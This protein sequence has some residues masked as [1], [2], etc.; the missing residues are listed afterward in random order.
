M[1]MDESSDSEKFFERVRES[2][3]FP[4]ILLPLFIILYGINFRT[5]L[6]GDSQAHL[7]L[8]A[9]LAWSGDFEL[10][11]YRARLTGNNA[12]KLPYFV[13]EE[14]SG[15]RSIFNFFP[16]VILVPAFAVGKLIDGKEFHDSLYLWGL[17]GKIEAS[18]F[19][20]L[21]GFLI[22]QIL[23]R[24][25]SRT[26]AY[27]IIFA[28]WFATPLWPTSVDYLQH[29]PLM[30]FK[31]LSL[32]LIFGSHD[33]DLPGRWRF[34][35]GGLTLSLSVLCR[36]QT[37]PSAILI[38]CFIICRYDLYKNKIFIFILGGLLPI[39]FTLWY[40]K[41]VFGSP[42]QTGPLIWLNFK[43]PF[44]S[45]VISL[46]VNPSKGL[47][48]HSPWILIGI[49]G[50][51]VSIIGKRLPGSN[52]ALIILCIISALPNFF[53]YSKLNGWYGGRCWG[54]RYLMDL[55]PEAAL[56][57]AFG[58]QIL[59]GVRFWRLL[60]YAAI[61]ISFFIQGV[62]A[63]AF[64]YEWHKVHV[65]GGAPDEIW[66]WQVPNSQIFYYIRRGLVYMGRMPIKLKASPYEKRGFYKPENWDDR[67]IAWLQKESSFYFVSR[68]HDPHIEV[69]AP[70]E[71]AVSSP[72]ILDIWING[73]K[74]KSVELKPI[75]WNRI[76]LEDIPFMHSAFIKLE[77]NMDYMEPGKLG[78]H[79]A[80]A[81]DLGNI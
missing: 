62:G 37:L 43:N 47:F 56:L 3:Y 1:T 14:D 12:H 18:I 68:S 52:R 11:E 73:K 63:L 48:M 21:A 39:P 22:W 19:A 64:D 57:T 15:L 23:Y 66:L 81:I 5:L 67:K 36:Y 41:A 33:D 44:F 78:R 4:L 17:A 49:I 27:I 72:L 59:W 38:A 60:T 16:A 29:H 6:V 35:A 7:Y 25:V 77:S 70:K 76:S 34:L 71:H 31:L 75:Y 13:V 61:L 46:L 28:F 74:A 24:R 45:T 79:I 54:Y 65:Y 80:V 51:V 69:Y 53:V 30:F 40:H 10:S 50:L 20:F 55:L 32:L 58:L 26:I 9:S 8:A 42:F 2:R